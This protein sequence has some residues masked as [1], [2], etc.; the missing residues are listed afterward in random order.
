M[1]ETAVRYM[2]MRR[3]SSVGADGIIYDNEDGALTR[4]R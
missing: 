3:D 1:G 4:F 2:W